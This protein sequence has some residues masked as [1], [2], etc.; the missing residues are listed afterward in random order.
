MI[1]ILASVSY[2]AYCS[3]MDYVRESQ[4]FNPYDHYDSI[5]KWIAT[6]YFADMD[7]GNKRKDCSKKSHEMHINAR[8]NNGLK[9]Q[10]FK[11]S[12][13]KDFASVQADYFDDNVQTWDITFEQLQEAY[14]T[15]AMKRHFP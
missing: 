6:Y 13:P 11:T 12:R 15:T 1:Y 3:M 5:V 10:D 7:K 9:P 14:K 8:N 4:L 2:D